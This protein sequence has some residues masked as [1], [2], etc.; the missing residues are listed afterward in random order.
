MQGHDVDL[1]GRGGGERDLEG[2]EESRRLRL[3]RRLGLNAELL[4]VGIGDLPR[5]RSIDG[6]LLLRIVI[7]NL[8]NGLE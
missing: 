8:S 3:S 6:G 2:G 5:F 1:L 4:C 7:F